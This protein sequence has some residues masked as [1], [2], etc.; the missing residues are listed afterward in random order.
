[1]NLCEHW[2]LRSEKLLSWNYYDLIYNLA[3]LYG[4]PCKHAGRR[5]RARFIEWYCFLLNVESTIL[6]LVSCKPLYSHRLFLYL[7]S[8]NKLAGGC[9]P[10]LWFCF[11]NKKNFC[12][13]PLEAQG[14]CWVSNLA[15]RMLYIKFI[16]MWPYSKFPLSNKYHWW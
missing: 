4:S 7:I 5:L 2:F 9:F 16:I 14:T 12:Y 8:F 10:N 3:C 6:W 11:F 1:M 15:S 13:C